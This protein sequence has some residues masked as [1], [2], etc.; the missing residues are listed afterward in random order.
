M[1]GSLDEHDAVG[2][3][4]LVQ[5]GE[6]K[7]TEVL[8]ASAQR[9]EERNPRLNAVVHRTYDQAAKQIAEGL[10]SGPF[11]GIPLLL[12]DMGT[13][14]AGIPLT[15]GSRLFENFVPG[16][17]STLAARYRR[18]GFVLIGRTNTPE[19]ALSFSCEPELFGPARN[20]WDS[21]RTAGGSSGGAAAAVASGMV[22]LAHASDGAGSTRVPAS[23][24]GVFG[25]K[26]TRMRNPMGPDVAEILAGMSTPHC[27][28]ISVRD[29][30]TL[31]DVTAGPDIGDPFAAPTPDRPFRAELERDPRPLKIGMM[32]RSPLGTSIDEQCLDRTKSAAKLLEEIGHRVEQTE[33]SYDCHALK[34]AWRLIAGVATA[35]MVF[36]RARHLR[37]GDPLPQ[38]EPVNREWVEEGR[39]IDG[40]AYLSAVETLHR[41]G[42]ALGRFFETYDVFLSPLTTELAP[43]LGEMASSGRSLATFYDRFWSH[44]PF[45]CAFNA[46]GGPAM[47]V[48][49]G[50]SAEGL[51]IGIHLGAALGE[52]GMLF[53][54]AG[55]LERAAPWRGRVAKPRAEH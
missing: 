44:S 40:I 18:A 15:L 21:S 16:A 54:L 3:A 35:R 24:C 45:T 13:A 27:I 51:P 46:S 31:L 37:M 22:P 52:D 36:A 19:F 17:D 8:D 34:D 49:L 7:A 50:E 9:I 26:P 38:L 39:G 43:R 42:R 14:A 32:L 25:F 48:P 55:Q 20:P 5:S 29:S 2:L 6:I 1:F 53:A 30:A 28:S 11:Q 4:G 41:V 12:K 10:P 33:M 23:H 47:S